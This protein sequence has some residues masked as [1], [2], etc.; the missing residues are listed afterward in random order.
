LQ[1]VN[2]ATR[3]F[4]NLQGRLRLQCAA[5]GGSTSSEVAAGSRSNVLDPAQ[6]ERQKY[7]PPS[8]WRAGALP[9]PAGGAPGPAS[10]A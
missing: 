8:H 1:A 7:S 9:P 3:R 5:A 10:P 4:A 6:A 2:G